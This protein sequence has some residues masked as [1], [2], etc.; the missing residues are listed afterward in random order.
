M[1]EDESLASQA[2]PLRN[3]HGDVLRSVLEFCEHHKD[4]P[5]LPVDVSEHDFKKLD[6]EGDDEEFSDWDASF[7]D[8]ELSRLF[9]LILVCCRPM[10][11]PF[12]Q[13]SLLAF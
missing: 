10:A 8:V 3:V 5:V 1:G 9:A 4:D 7:C 13:F 12:S 11:T 6:G 2:I